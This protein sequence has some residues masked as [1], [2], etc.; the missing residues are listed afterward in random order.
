MQHELR[1]HQNTIQKPGVRNVRNPSVD[2]HAG[3]ENFMVMPDVVSD[4]E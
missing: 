3:I 1:N 4:A 2:N